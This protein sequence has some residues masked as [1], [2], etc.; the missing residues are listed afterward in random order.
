MSSAP[1]ANPAFASCITRAVSPLIIARTGLADAMYA[2]SLTGTV[3]SNISLLFKDRKS[4]SSIG[5]IEEKV[6]S[7]VG[8]EF[9]LVGKISFLEY[10][11][12]EAV[13]THQDLVGM[14]VYP[15]R[16]TIE[17]S[18]DVFVAYSSCCA[19]AFGPQ[20]QYPETEWYATT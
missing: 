6:F 16:H 8:K 15:S 18:E 13:R 19:E 20:V 4:M 11:L 1:V 17:E 14:A 2:C 7:P 12:P 3:R 5:L 9:Q 10:R